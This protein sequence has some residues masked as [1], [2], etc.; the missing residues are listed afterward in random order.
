GLESFDAFSLSN[1]LDGAPAGYADRLHR[2][3]R[4]AAV[5]GAVLVSRSF[6]E[7]VSEMKS[8]WAERDRSF[9]WG[10]VNVTFIVGPQQ[11]DPFC[12][13]IRSR[14]QLSSAIALSWPTRFRATSYVRCFRPVWYWIRTVNTAFWRSLWCRPSGCGPRFYRACSVETSFLPDTVSLRVWMVERNAIEGCESCGARR[15]SVQ[16]SVRVICLRIIDTD[17]VRLN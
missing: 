10:I 9:L 14:S 13:V 1:I 12:I 2:A 4:R 7:P 5:P 15:T 16:W 17:S 6:A 8:N 3:V 11:C